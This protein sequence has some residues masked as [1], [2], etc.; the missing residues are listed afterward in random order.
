MRYCA[1]IINLIVKKEL[2]E[3]KDSM[4][5]IHDAI[6]YVRSSPQREQRFKGSVEKERIECNNSLCLDVATRWNFTY[7]VLNVAIKF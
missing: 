6:K 4:S 7:L 2:S 1:H 3:I 5:R